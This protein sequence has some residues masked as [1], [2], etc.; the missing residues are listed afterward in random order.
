MGSQDKGRSCPSLVPGSVAETEPSDILH[1]GQF[2]GWSGKHLQELGWGGDFYA[3][4]FV[5]GLRG[6]GV[7]LGL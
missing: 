3:A 6:F 4:V 2:A 5:L 1:R 7:E